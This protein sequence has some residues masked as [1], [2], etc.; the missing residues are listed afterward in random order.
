MALLLLW[1][2]GK[3]MFLIRALTLS[4]VF[5]CLLSCQE[6][7]QSLAVRGGHFRVNMVSEPT[8]IDPSLAS[9]ETSILVASLMYEGLLD[10]DKDLKLVPA[11]AKEVP[12]KA[13][14]GISSD[15]LT[16]TFNLRN[17]SKW[18]D[19]QSVKA[20]DFVYAIKRSLDPTL[21]AIYA[22]VLYDIEGAKAYSQA[23]KTSSADHLRALRDAVN[24][25]A[26][27]DWTLV[28][29]LHSPRP[30]FLHLISTW[31]AWPQRQDQVEKNPHMG[32]GPFQLTRW[33]HN[34]SLEF[35]PNPHYAG[36]RSPKLDK[37]TLVQIS[38][39][40]KAF[41]AY[42][43]G[44]VDAVAVPVLKAAELSVDPAYASQLVRGPTLS[45]FG[46]SFNCKAAPFQ[47]VRVR[48]AFA[49][50]ID[51]G[52]HLREVFNGVGK[53]AFSPTPPGM[54]GHDPEVGQDIGFNPARAK[55]LLKEAGYGDA[56]KFPTI[57]FMTNTSSSNQI[58][59]NF[60]KEQLKA[61]LGV[62]VV[63]EV[64]AADVSE[65]RI[66]AKDFQ[67][68]FSGWNADYPDPDNIVPEVFKSDSSNNY[69]NYSNPMA[70]ALMEK[71]QNESDEATRL[72]SCIS[73][74]KMVVGDVPWVFMAYR[75]RL[76]L[77]KPSVKGFQ[78][79]ANEELPG[80]RFYHQVFVPST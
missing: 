20:N 67:M 56:K 16:Y 34:E 24:V 25:R 38:D 11:L 68:S 78:L 19:G 18:S 27:D 66:A 29:K 70:D 54:P 46:V 71:C 7:A 32:N 48:K 64:V 21:A 53:V 10:Y 4:L 2:K 42:L 47:D 45:I 57:T 43:R 52:A 50:A 73:A 44:E 13:N 77:V 61:N 62:D 51:R 3:S 49:M 1:H 22:Q 60:L 75:E 12:T 15:G 69:F 40:Q 36:A 28:V 59:F 74:Q 72:Q 79:T 30:S 33:N 35:A 76:W 26:V 8:T 63:H 39:D 31:V 37:L 5:A 14:G 58:R 17:D 9:F 65:K 80:S 6:N 23:T 55:E 41:E